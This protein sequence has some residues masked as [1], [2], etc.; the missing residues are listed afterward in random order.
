[1]RI[2]TLT[3][4]HKQADAT[5]M[6]RCLR[7]DDRAWEVLLE[8]YGNLIYSIGWKCHLPPEDIA[9]VFQSVCLVLMEDLERLK[10]KTNLTPWLTTIT[11][12]Q[13]RHLVELDQVDEDLAGSSDG[14]VLPEEALQQLVQQWSLTESASTTD[15]PLRQLTESVG[16]ASREILDPP[17][18]LLRQA[19]SLFAWHKTKPR[20][21]AVKQIPAFLLV[22]SYAEGQ[23]A[24]FRSVGPMPRQMLYRA[25]D[26][27]LNLSINHMEQA[28]EIDI[29]GQ[30]LP[31]NADLGA[32]VE[33]DVELLKEST[34]AR[35]TKANEF[36]AFILDGVQEGTYDL[37]IRLKDEEIHIMKLEAIVRTPQKPVVN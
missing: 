5:L 28:E 11:L 7:G 27:H 22:D 33:A 10:E 14:S 23:L 12:Q 2:K 16:G 34:A 30:P 6:N 15:E 4:Y 8:R 37:K 25:G 3:D 29:M 19:V 13:C 31:L 36:G 35:A 26:Y 1:M 24:G 9:D 21:N 32:V 18:W 17:E 20:G